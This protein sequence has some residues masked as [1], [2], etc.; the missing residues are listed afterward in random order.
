ME[1]IICQLCK[2]QIET[3]DFGDGILD[4][5]D[6]YEYRGFDFHEKCFDEGCKKVDAKRNEV[7]NTVDKSIRSQADGQWHNGGYKNMK[8]GSD[9]KPITKVKEPQILKD[10]ENGIL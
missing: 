9:G 6:L 4:Y 10:Y 1:T 2:K 8:T 3:P 5:S 7:I